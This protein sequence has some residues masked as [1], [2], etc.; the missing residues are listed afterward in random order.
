MPFRASITLNPKSG[1]PGTPVQVDG[2]NFGALE[3]VVLTFVDSANGPEEVA[4]VSTDG[5]GAFATQVAVPLNATPGQQ[6]VSAFGPRSGQRLN[7]T[8]TVT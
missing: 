6:K 5:T 4:R 7:R 1:T 8:F 3:T 2:T